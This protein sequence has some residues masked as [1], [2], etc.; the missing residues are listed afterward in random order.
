MVES[1]AADGCNRS[2]FNYKIVGI[3]AIARF[4]EGG[5]VLG[6]ISTFCNQRCVRI[7]GAG[8]RQSAV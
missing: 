2:I 7:P 1:I 8:N 5:A 3:Q 4:D 6:A